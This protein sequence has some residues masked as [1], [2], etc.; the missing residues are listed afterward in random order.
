MT[1]YTDAP[2]NDKIQGSDKDFEYAEAK[3]PFYPG[4]PA[5]GHPRRADH[6]HA[7]EAAQPGKIDETL[8]QAGGVRFRSYSHPRSSSAAKP[9]AM[10]WDDR[11]R[12]W[13][14]ITKEYPNEMQR[15]GEG[16]RQDRD[17]RRHRRRRRG[18]PV[19]H[20]RRQAEHPHQ[21]A[22]R[23][24]RSARPA[25]PGT[26]CSLK[27]TD[28]DGK[29]DLRQELITGWG[30]NDTH[31]GPSNLRYGFDNWVYGI[32]EDSGLNGTVAGAGGSGS[33]RASTASSWS[34]TAST[35]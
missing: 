18:R 10:T 27:D 32:V 23:P 21:P 15:Q 13:V 1:T 11:G 3:V 29:A 17:L 20:L 5:V 14:S 12:L 25:G 30:I 34:R 6:Q 7:E 24:R 35:S 8:Q 4:W 22:V 16:Q 19:H 31:A 2:E 28:G 26:P 9:I 33:A